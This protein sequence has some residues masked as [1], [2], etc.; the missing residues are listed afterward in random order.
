MPQNFGFAAKSMATL[1]SSLT[2]LVDSMEAEVA[3]RG[4]I[5]QESARELRSLRLKTEQLF[6]YTPTNGA[7]T[8]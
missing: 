7:P 2:D 5:S 8:A 1:G 4:M 6:T 3:D